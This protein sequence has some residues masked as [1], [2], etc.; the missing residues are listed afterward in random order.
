MIR[1]WTFVDAIDSLPLAGIAHAG[2][3]VDPAQGAIA[4]GAQEAPPVAEGAQE[5]QPFEV[6]LQEADCQRFPDELDDVRHIVDQITGPLGSLAAALDTM[7]QITGSI[8]G[9]RGESCSSRMPR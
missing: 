9:R 6:R 4:E 5:A 7:S 1:P 3:S 2:L 8:P